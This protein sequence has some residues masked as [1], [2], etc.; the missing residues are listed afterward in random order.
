MGGASLKMQVPNY[1]AVCIIPVALEP[2][3]MVLA[4]IVER[5][6]LFSTATP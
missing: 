2:V 1:C 3:L 5:I 4:N 6:R